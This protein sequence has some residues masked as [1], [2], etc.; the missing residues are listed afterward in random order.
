MRVLILIVALFVLSAAK[1]APDQMYATG[2]R[3]YAKVILP[4]YKAYLDKDPDLEERSKE[5]RTATADEW[6]EFIEEGVDD[7][8]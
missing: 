8:E 5:I 1:C 2:N 3:D 7:D 6:M 4:R